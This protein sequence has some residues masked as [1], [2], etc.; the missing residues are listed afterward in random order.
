MN[1]FLANRW[2]T[3]P[4]LVVASAV[5]LAIPVIPVLASSKIDVPVAQSV[6]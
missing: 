3:I 2:F 1:K 4:L 5:A 6:G